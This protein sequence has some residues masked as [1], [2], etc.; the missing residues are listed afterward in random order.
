VQGFAKE[1]NQENSFNNN[2][3]SQVLNGGPEHQRP[4]AREVAQEP[5]KKFKSDI[6]LGRSIHGPAHM[7]A[8][9]DGA[10]S[11]QENVE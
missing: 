1:I 11:R 2:V 3:K 5:K 10:E 7:E 6:D 4:A 9:I 8:A